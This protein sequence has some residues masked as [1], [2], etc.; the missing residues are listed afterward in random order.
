MSENVGVS[1]A[2]LESTAAE[3]SSCKSTMA[4]HLSAVL[5]AVEGIQSN[6]QS[7]ESKQLKTIAGNMQNKFTL[8]EKEVENF[9]TWL[10]NAASNYKIV[11]STADDILGKIGSQFK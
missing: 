2:K 10:S 7:E 11:A 3:L 1:Q 8:M 6:Y 4:N 5:D 9:V